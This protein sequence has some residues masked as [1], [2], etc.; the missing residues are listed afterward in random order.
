MVKGGKRLISRRIREERQPSQF[1]VSR[2]LKKI[3]QHVDQN[4]VRLLLLDPNLPHIT[5]NHRPLLSTTS[6]MIPSMSSI[7][8]ANSSSTMLLAAWNPLIAS[9]FI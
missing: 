2:S 1:S 4:Q 5:V 3:L 8:F 7:S 6:S 9:S